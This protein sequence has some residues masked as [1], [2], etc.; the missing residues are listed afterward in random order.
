M[1]SVTRFRGLQRPRQLLL[2]SHRRSAIPCDG[3]RETTFHAMK[4]SNAGGMTATNETNRNLNPGQRSDSLAIVVRWAEW[5][6]QSV[7][8]ASGDR[9]PSAQ[10]HAA[11]LKTLS[12]GRPREGKVTRHFHPVVA[13]E[14]HRNSRRPAIRFAAP[15]SQ[16]HVTSP[17]GVGR[18]RG[19]ADSLRDASLSFSL[20]PEGAASLTSDAIWRRVVKPTTLRPVDPRSKGRVSQVSADGIPLARSLGCGTSEHSIRF[21]LPAL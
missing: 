2:R 4:L 15:G 13:G 18:R 16:S 14:S 3:T 21:S 11:G 5:F 19:S 9:F 12:S 8:K 20:A 7:R 10:R 1:L 17:D 6:A